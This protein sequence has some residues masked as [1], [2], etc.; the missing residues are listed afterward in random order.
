M[1]ER[2]TIKIR[3]SEW[4]QLAIDGLIRRALDEEAAL[5]AIREND[6]RIEHELELES[7]RIEQEAEDLR[8]TLQYEEQ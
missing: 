1:D 3:L 4:V 2:Y 8:L 5:Q 6:A 7:I